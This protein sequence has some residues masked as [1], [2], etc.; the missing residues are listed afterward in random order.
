MDII[1]GLEKEHVTLYLEKRVRMLIE[2]E[3][4]GNK[5]RYSTV[6]NR[7]MW[8]ALKGKYNLVGA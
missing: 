7:V 5:E 6:V 1:G 3:A 8:E 4:K 2:K